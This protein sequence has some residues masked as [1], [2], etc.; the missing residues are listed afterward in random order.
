MSHK[1]KVLVGGSLEISFSHENFN[2]GMRSCFFVLIFVG[3][4]KTV[5]LGNGGFA[6]CRKQ[7][8]LTKTAKMTN[9]TH[10][11]KGFGPQNPENDENDENGR[12]HSSKPMVDQKRGFHNPDFGPLRKSNR[13]IQ[14]TIDCSKFSAPKASI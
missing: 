4:V 8:I 14:S 1:I 12:C 7:G 9:S 13:K 5:V 2:S 6:P 10:E 3:V 11:N